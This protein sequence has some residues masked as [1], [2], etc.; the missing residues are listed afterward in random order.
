MRFNVDLF[1]QV[2]HRWHFCL[3]ISVFLLNLDPVFRWKRNIIPETMCLNIRARERLLLG[4]HGLW[5][6]RD[7]VRVTRTAPFSR[8]LLTTASHLDPIGAVSEYNFDNSDRKYLY[9]YKRMLPA[10]QWLE[11]RRV[12]IPLWDVGAGPSDETVQI[13][14]PC[15]SKC[16]T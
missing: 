2:H 13:K 14:V 6:G 9:M 4:I 12:R 8:L 11:R 7:L 5:E 16:G 10:F 1:L 15:R 3:S